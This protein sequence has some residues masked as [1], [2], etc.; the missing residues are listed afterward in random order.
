MKI[1]HLK[2]A[3]LAPHPLLGRAGMLSDLIER[4][5]KKGNAAGS[6]REA[7]KA[8][9]AE[10]ETEYTAFKEGIRTQ[11]IQDP[12]KVVKNP[13][14]SYWIVDGRNRWDSHKDVAAEDKPLACVEIPETD[15]RQ[16][17]LTAMIR[18]HMTKQARALMA[19][20]IHPEVAQEAKAGRPKQG[21]EYPINQPALAAIVGVSL[22]TMKEACLFWREIALENKTKREERI[23]QVLGG[24]SFDQVRDGKPGEETKGKPREAEKPALLLLRNANSMIRQWPSWDALTPEARVNTTEK[25][26]EA[27]RQ[28]PREIREAVT[29]A[30]EADA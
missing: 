29:A 5:T 30:W 20:Q 16:V 7:H 23:S 18:R 12:L 11:G 25:M 27:M 22:E 1:L 4:E 17:I 24:I 13:D 14:G 26:A 8:R 10:L 6:N 28:A 2:A 15:V 3:E 21:A 19:V 9:A